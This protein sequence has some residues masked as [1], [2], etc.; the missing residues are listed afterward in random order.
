MSKSDNIIL[1]AKPDSRAEIENATDDLEIITKSMISFHGLE[2]NILGTFYQDQLDGSRDKHLKFGADIEDF[3]VTG[4]LRVYRP[5]VGA[6]GK[7]VNY[8]DP[9]RKQ[10][11]EKDAKQAG[12]KESPEPIEIAH[13]RYTSSNKILKVKEEDKVPFNI[14]P[15]DF[16]S[17]RTGVF[18][19]TRTGKSNTI[20]TMIS[21]NALAAAKSKNKVGQIIFDLNGEYANANNQDDGSSI[22]DVF[23]DNTIRYRGISTTGFFDFRN[24]L[25]RSLNEGLYLL[26]ELVRNEMA[27]S[28]IATDMQ[29]LLSLDLEEPLQRDAKSRWMKKVAIY[30]SILFKS[31]LPFTESDDIVKFE[32]SQFALFDIYEAIFAQEDSESPT[33]QS[34]KVERAKNL[35]GNGNP[36]DLEAGVSLEKAKEI[37]EIIRSADKA[38][39]DG[40]D[41]NRARFGI[42][43][44]PN[45][46]W[47]NDEERALLNVL[48]GKSD[49]N[50]NIRGT[51]VI[52]NAVFDYHSKK[53]SENVPRDIYDHLLKGRIVILDLSVG[54]EQIA[55]VQSEAIAR[56]IRNQSFK[57]FIA[58]EQPPN[59][60]LYVEEA[61][62]IIGKDSEPTETWPRV[63]KEGAKAGLS[64][65]YA[66]QEPSSV[67][68]N[69]LSNTENIF[70]TH[71]NNDDEVK[72]LSKFYDFADFSKSIKK[73]QDVGFAR[74]KTLSSA[75]VVPAQIKL[76]EPDK[77]KEQYYR[78]DKTN[79]F[80][81]APLPE[82]DD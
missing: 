36:I 42:R 21:M 71:V 46:A 61:H 70:A 11:V 32:I 64:L 15:M 7:I 80:E 31:G 19:M 24:N 3:H 39:R 29:T 12:F 34:D 59:I 14:H 72:V 76:F 1:L 4:M 82:N 25:Y 78:C 23:S 45:S 81:S 65:V 22:A 79:D 55:E 41:P 40:G 26:Q 53:G 38:I 9:I 50:T 20:K 37:F 54:S 27:G 2:C 49:N 13:V 62:N 48:V 68:P 6:L 51:K 8:V 5:S 10:K 69:I 16:I 60:V 33:S 30:K 47:L 57:K 66:T 52:K 74:I 67:Q 17:R 58:G 56:Y 44:R 63:A 18:G 35:L 75:F 28:T 43:S 77:V 73:A